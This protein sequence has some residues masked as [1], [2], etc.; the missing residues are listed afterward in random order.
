MN[1]D[2]IFTVVIIFLLVGMMAAAIIQSLC[3][4]KLLAVALLFL[5]AGVLIV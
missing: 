4:L 3:L 1:P 2:T 5:A